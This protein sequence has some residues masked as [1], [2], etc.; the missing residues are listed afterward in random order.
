MGIDIIEISRLSRIISRYG[1]KFIS[2]IYTPAEADFGSRAN[3]ARAAIYYAGRW[4]AKEAFYK[5]LP[6]DVQPLSSWLSVQIL[7][8]GAGRPCIEVCDER[9]R[10]ALAGIG[11]SSVHL[12]ITHERTHCAAVVIVE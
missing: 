7:A 6:A 10:A 2:R 5:A 9:L 12:S 8:D 1:G 11:V 4:A 3:E